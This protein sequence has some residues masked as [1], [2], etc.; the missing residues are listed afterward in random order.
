MTEILKS[1]VF[2]KTHLCCISL[3]S[4]LDKNEE[5]NIFG[6][7]WPQKLAKKSKKCI[8]GSKI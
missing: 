5:K 3:E 6:P 1:W 4:S 7:F 8:L 2:A